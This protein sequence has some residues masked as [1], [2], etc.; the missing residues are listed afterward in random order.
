M[1]PSLII[2]N[3]AFKTIIKLMS[4]TERRLNFKFITE[5]SE[6]LNGLIK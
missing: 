3:N 6:D 4:I 5:Q 2:T 1:H